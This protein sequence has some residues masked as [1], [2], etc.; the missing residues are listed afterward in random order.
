MFVEVP[1]RLSFICSQHCDCSVHVSFV[2][3]VFLKYT[4][5]ATRFYRT[6]GWVTI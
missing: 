2:P 3:D 5:W 1:S 4:E 6:M